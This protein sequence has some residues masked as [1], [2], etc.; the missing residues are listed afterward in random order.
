MSGLL[1]VFCLFFH[2][3]VFEHMSLF[4]GGT[5]CHATSSILPRITPCSSINSILFYVPWIYTSIEAALRII[6]QH[7]HNNNTFLIIAFPFLVGLLQF[8][9]GT[10]YEMQ[11]PIN[12]FW[13]WP[14]EYGIIAQSSTLLSSWN[15]YPPISL[16]NDA[17]DLQEVATI[18]INGIFRVSKHAGGALQQR[19]YKFPIFAPYF[20]FAFGFAWAMGLVLLGSNSIFTTAGSLKNIMLAGL[21]TPILFLF[22]IWITRGMSDALNLPYSYGVPLSL[23]V[24]ILLVLFLLRR[25][26]NKQTTT[27]TTTTTTTHPSLTTSDPL[28]F[29]ISFIMHAFMVSF[30]FY[31]KVTTTIIPFGLL[32]LV[33]STSIIHLSAQYYCC[34]V[35]CTT[36]NNNNAKSK[37]KSK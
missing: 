6:I 5:H 33:T 29:S 37:S 31:R 27:T 13:K 28:L 25:N 21:M 10:V 18:D 26:N 1:I 7:K 8:G 15:N 34:F 14:D 24:S 32:L 36:S 12:N 4:L 2:T 3:I 20:H 35:C 17:K 9:F 23:L 22:P 11:G 30:L 16:L 19:L